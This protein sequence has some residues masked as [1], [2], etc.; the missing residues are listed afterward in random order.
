MSGA[1]E[2]LAGVTQ[3]T[4]R[5]RAW[6]DAMARLRVAMIRKHQGRIEG[7]ADQ[8]EGQVARELR[9]SIANLNEGN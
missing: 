5:E 1:R 3:P 2:Y 7:D 8:L 9:C 4:G 6:A